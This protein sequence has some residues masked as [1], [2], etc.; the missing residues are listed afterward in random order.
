MAHNDME[1]GNRGHCNRNTGICACEYGF[2]GQ[3]CERLDCPNDCSS[4]G[5]CLSMH[6]AGLD[7]HPSGVDY[8]NWDSSAVLG[9][10]CD[11]GFHGPDCSLRYCPKGDD[12]KTEN[13]GYRT[14]RMNTTSGSSSETLG[15]KFQLTFD[16]MSF[17]FSAAAENFTAAD[18]KSAWESLDNVESV[19]CKRSQV[20]DDRGSSYIVQFNGWPVLPFQNNYDTHD[21]NP[22][23]SQF[24][25]SAADATPSGSASCQMFDVVSSDVEEYTECSSRGVCD[26]DTGTCSCFDGFSN[27]NC[28]EI[29]DD[30]DLV[31][32]NQADILLLHSRLATYEGNVLHIRSDRAKSEAFNL[33]KFEAGDESVFTL[34]GDGDLTMHHGG[35]AIHEGGAVVTAGGLAVTSG[36]VTVGSNGL[37]VARGGLTVGGGGFRLENSD[38][39]IANGSIFAVTDTLDEPALYLQVTNADYQGS[40]LV[41]AAARTEDPKFNLFEAVYDFDGIPTTIFAINGEPHTKIETGGL[42]LVG[43]LNIS[44]GGLLVQAGGVTISSGGVKIRHGDINASDSTLYVRKLS[45]S[46]LEADNVNITNNLWVGNNAVVKDRFAADTIIC[47]KL[48]ELSD[49]T[50]KTDITPLAER[51]GRLFDLEG[52]SFRWRNNRPEEGREEEEGESA[53]SWDVDDHRKGN[54]TFGFIAQDVAEIFPELV[55]EDP[56]SDSGLLSVA[57]SSITPLLVEA[58]K[59]QRAESEDLRGI[60]ATLLARVTSLED[61]LGRQEQESSRI[62]S[63]PHD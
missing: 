61:R 40:A 53:S 52:V 39:T 13:D 32:L 46:E 36:G 57:Y 62:R 3:A 2:T 58:L 44:S 51:A 34:R 9:C 10:K 1:C 54:K 43:G 6:R 35:L 27:V 60:V 48:T 37:S 20:Q 17:D 14:I 7:L 4:N 42:H 16:G 22:S 26:E 30:P 50:L 31:S 47:K 8:T 5:V 21:G 11:W 59:T 45:V 41:V 24:A 19:T 29:Y 55:S 33:L 63:N 18:C 28:D 15:G 12:P 56:D 23:I 25:C 49:A 38:A